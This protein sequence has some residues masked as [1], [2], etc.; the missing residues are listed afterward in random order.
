MM[1][2]ES[3]GLGQAIKTALS[4][5]SPWCRGDRNSTAGEW[6][7]RVHAH[8]PSRGGHGSQSHFRHEA[9]EAQTSSGSC[10]EPQGQEEEGSVGSG[11]QLREAG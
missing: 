11:L 7:P 4:R 8:E 1:S 3:K 10:L 5:E 9:T 2:E 6:Q